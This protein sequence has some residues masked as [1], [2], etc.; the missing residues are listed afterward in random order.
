MC[1]ENVSTVVLDNGDISSVNPGLIQT[2]TA[3]GNGSSGGSTGRISK[4]EPELG[5]RRVHGGTR[6][7]GHPRWASDSHPR[8]G[9]SGL[10]EPGHFGDFF[11]GEVRQRRGGVFPDLCRRRSACD[12]GRDDRM[13]G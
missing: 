12:D 7:D 11:G 5:Y 1:P 10:D 8:R 3:G 2:G 6:H 4:E 13:T 9:L